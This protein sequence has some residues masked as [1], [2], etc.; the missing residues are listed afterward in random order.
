[1]RV[2]AQAIGVKR[3]TYP[4]GVEGN[5]Y[6][7]PL[8]ALSVAAIVGE[9]S[10]EFDAPLQFPTPFPNELGLAVP[11]G[12][13]SERVMPAIYQAWRLKQLTALYGGSVVE[14][15]AGF[16]RTAFY[17]VTAAGISDYTIIDLPMANAAQASFLGRSLGTGRICLYGERHQKGQIR[18]MPSRWFNK[19]RP[20][21]DVVLN[22]DSLTEMPMADANAYAAW[23]MASSK[24]LLSI[25][26]EANEFVVRNLPALAHKCVGRF[27]LMIRPGYVEEIYTPAELMRKDAV[28]LAFGKLLTALARISNRLPQRNMFYQGFI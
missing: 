22:V 4:E 1:M 14:I 7:E 2:L 26:H 9:L 12:I 15:G 3:V 23:S 18:I 5:I 28:S 21:C 20:S 10:E 17:A 6:N 25:N 8:E 11:G 19:S 13:A 24:V 27:P 16:G